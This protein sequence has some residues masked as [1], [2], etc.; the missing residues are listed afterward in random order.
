MLVQHLGEVV[1]PQRPQ[2]LG[3]VVHHE[4]VMTGEQVD[5]HLWN[6]PPREVV[7]DAINEG[8]VV[9]NHIG[10]RRKEM[11]RLNHHVDRLVGIA[12]HGDACIT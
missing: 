5:P 1:F 3:K 2:G 7:V 8:H 12:E 9:A 11:P 6:L 4:A 10:H